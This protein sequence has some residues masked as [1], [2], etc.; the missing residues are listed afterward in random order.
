MAPGPLRPRGTRGTHARCLH[1]R[2]QA[3]LPRRAARPAGRG[4]DRLAQSARNRGNNPQAAPPGTGG[5]A[6]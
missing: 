2:S 1:Q 3:L 4:M 6:V 5:A